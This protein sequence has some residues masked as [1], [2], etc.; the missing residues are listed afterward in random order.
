MRIFFFPAAGERVITHGTDKVRPGQVVR[1]LAVDD[2]SKS[3][4]EMLEASP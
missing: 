2:G 3:L 4:K 1:V